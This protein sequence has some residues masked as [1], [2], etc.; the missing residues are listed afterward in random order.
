MQVIR[1]K[2]YEIYTKILNGETEESFQI[3]GQSFTLKEWDKLLEQF[4][5]AEEAIKEASVQTAEEKQES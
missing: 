1:D 3:G 2:I 4:D 5:L